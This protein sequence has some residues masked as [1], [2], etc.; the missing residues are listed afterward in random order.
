MSPFWPISFNSQPPAPILP[1]MDC[2]ER[3][4][5]IWTSCWE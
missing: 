2:G 1:V 5:L 3:S 4:P